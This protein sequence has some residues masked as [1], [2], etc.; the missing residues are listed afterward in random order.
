MTS[1]Q[2]G[3]PCTSLE[4]EGGMDS[5]FREAAMQKR[6]MSGCHTPHCGGVGWAAV[7]GAALSGP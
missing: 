3:P 4:M 7:T 1:T 5:L 6:C 2:A